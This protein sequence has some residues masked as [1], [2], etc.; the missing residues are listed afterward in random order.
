MAT[1]LADALKGVISEPEVT[2]PDTAEAPE[3]VEDSKGE[4]PEVETE[5]VEA[6]EEPKQEAE[7]PTAKPTKEVPLPALLDERDKRKK[8]ETE[9]EA[10]RQQ[11][12]EKKEA[13][14]FWDDPEKAIAKE[15][16]SLEAKFEHKLQE[17]MLRYSIKSAAGRHDDYNDAFEAFKEAAA[18]NP[19]LSNMAAD[20]DDPGD[21]IYRI[22]KNFLQ[23]DQAG[24]DVEAMRESIRAEE[25]QKI[26]AE[27]KAKEEKHAN[28]PQSITDET[29]ASA[30]REKVEGG[31]TPLTSILPNA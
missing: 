21:E 13:P 9:L 4:E 24:G 16:Q 23:L 25:R 5:A 10:L 3:V 11:I 30:P 12:E 15:V 20:S 22:G 29:S 27:L 26:L 2:E 14:N 31:P 6:A 7:P 19:S 18:E 8:A 28:V 17:R 1:S